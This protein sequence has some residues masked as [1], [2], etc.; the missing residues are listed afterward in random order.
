MPM[1]IGSKTGG[2]VMT[3]IK[4]VRVMEMIM[5]EVKAEIMVTGAVMEMK[6]I[7]AK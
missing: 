7:M 1:K 2:S 5:T 6:A 4:T 3:I